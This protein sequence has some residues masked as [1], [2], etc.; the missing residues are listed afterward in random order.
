MSNKNDDSKY[1]VANTD[2]YGIKMTKGGQKY[3]ICHFI[4]NNIRDNYIP[5]QQNLSTSIMLENEKGKENYYFEP[6]KDRVIGYIIGNAGSIHGCKT[7]NAKTNNYGGLHLNKDSIENFISK[8]DS[9]LKSYEKPSKIVVPEGFWNYIAGKKISEI[10]NVLKKND[11]FSNFYYNYLQP[12][13]DPYQLKTVDDLKEFVNEYNNKTFGPSNN[14]L[15]ISDYDVKSMIINLSSDKFGQMNRKLSLERVV[16][17]MD[18][19][20]NIQ[21]NKLGHKSILVRDAGSKKITKMELDKFVDYI[22]EECEKIG[23]DIKTINKNFPTKEDVKKMINPKP[24]PPKKHRWWCRFKKWF[25]NLFSFNYHDK[26]NAHASYDTNVIKNDIN[27][28]IY[29]NM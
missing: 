20:I 26:N 6:F 11:L 4:P 5:K 19:I 28:M 22:K 14:Q 27:T 3:L 9:N 12:Y 17:N 25:K 16:K 8:L 18:S 21:F 7:D 15:N 10:E 29:S 23:I 13:I 1:Q 24:T 2:E